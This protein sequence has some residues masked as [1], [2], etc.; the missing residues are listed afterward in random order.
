MNQQ[1]QL[2]LCFYCSGAM[3]VGIFLAN[4]TSLYGWTALVFAGGAFAAGL[5][6]QITKF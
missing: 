3:G 6:T 1:M 5:I 2:A 4:S